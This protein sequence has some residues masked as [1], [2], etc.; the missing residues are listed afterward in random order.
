MKYGRICG[1]MSVT[2]D[3]SDRILRLPLYYEMTDAEVKSVVSA[4]SGFYKK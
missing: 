4:L 3:V 2:N 1:K